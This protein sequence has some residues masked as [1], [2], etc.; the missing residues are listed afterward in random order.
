MPGRPAFRRIG[1]SSTHWQR[2]SVG[3]RAIRKSTNIQNRAITQFQQ[4]SAPIAAKSV[5]DTAF[6]R[7]GRLLSRNDVGFEADVLGIS[8]ADFHARVLRRQTDFPH[9][10]LATATHDHKRGEDVRA[11]LAVL[12]E[13]ADRMGEHGAGLDR[14]MRATAAPIGRRVASAHRRH[15][16][17][18]ADNRGSVATRSRGEGSGRTACVRRA[19]RAL[20]G[21]GVARGETC[22]RLVRTERGIRIRGAASHG[23]SRRGQRPARRAHRHRDIRQSASAP[24]A[25]S[26]VSPRLC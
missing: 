24:Q 19:A 3:V 10:M 15:R 13:R 16:D 17:A 6:Y 21:E 18:V 23:G 2:G 5:E 4:L 14:A 8:P 9:A 7:Y 11:R 1:W 22:D 12:S 20:A 25:P 26:M